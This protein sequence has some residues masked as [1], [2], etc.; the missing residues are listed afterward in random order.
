MRIEL[1]LSEEEIISL[2]KRAKFVE[3]NT[4]LLEQIGIDAWDFVDKFSEE[5][6]LQGIMEQLCPW[7]EDVV[8]ELIYDLNISPEETYRRIVNPTLEELGVE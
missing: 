3:R 1:E 8:W 6:L 4:K 2:I 7:D 5:T